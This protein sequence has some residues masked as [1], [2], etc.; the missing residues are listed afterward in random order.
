MPQDRRVNRIRGK[1][2]HFIGKVEVGGEGM[3]G[4]FEFM[5]QALGLARGTAALASPNPQVGCV[6]VAGGQ[7]IGQGAH[8]YD[9]RDHAE[10]VALKQA[11]ALGH[12]TRGATAYVT[13]E[14]CSHHGRTGPCAD[15][16][17][18]AGIARCVVATV[19]PNPL[20]SGRGIGR[21]RAAGVEAVVGVCQ[22][23]ARALNDA[24]AW[25]ITQGRPFVTLKAALSTDGMLA[26]PPNARRANEPHWL[27]GPLARAEVQQLRH[28]SD[29]ILT[30]IGTVL[31]DDPAL[32]DRT[33]LPR[34]RPLLRIV[35]DTNLRIPL[36]SR[37][38]K[39]ASEDLWIVC[40]RAAA[41]RKAAK[42]EALQK[43][44][45]I[46]TE[47][48]KEAQ[49][50]PADVLR[51]VQGFG[52]EF[53]D[54]RLLSILLEAGST[55]NGVFL[56]AGLVDRAILYYAPVELGPAAVPFALAG[57]TPFQLEQQF[58]AVSKAIVGP[59]VRVSGLLHDPWASVAES[60]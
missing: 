45:V 50:G 39:T 32:T 58:R 19:D 56:R 37:L 20:V 10:V 47:N 23:E 30:G 29:A 44:G 28:A 41:R 31:A 42:F 3:A 55:L 60:D 18:A 48:P 25:S 59:D 51:H 22:A 53:A 27:T 9:A 24:F 16:L 52:R 34:R 7:V 12:S 54:F 4:D 11:A 6:L 49:L 26:P 14:P 17:I 46:L 40:S 8:L 43:K 38:V 1:G 15:A 35:L 21:L 2:R 13:L 36:T 5:Q 57:P 33:G